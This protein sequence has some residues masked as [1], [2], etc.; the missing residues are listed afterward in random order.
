VASFLIFL[1]VLVLV[2]G[3]DDHVPPATAATASAAPSFP[4]SFEQ[5]ISLFL[6]DRL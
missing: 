4:T 1:I 3:T 5:F 6:Q 2:I